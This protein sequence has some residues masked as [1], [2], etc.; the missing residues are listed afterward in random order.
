M[1]TNPYLDRINKLYED[2]KISTLEYKKAVSEFNK[3]WN[4]EQNMIPKTWLVR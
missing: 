1:K 2:G 4:E 3:Q